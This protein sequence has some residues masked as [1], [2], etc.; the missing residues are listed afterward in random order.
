MNSITTKEAPMSPPSRQKRDVPSPEEAR[1]AQID[2]A[3][4]CAVVAALLVDPIG[5]NALLEQLSDEQLGRM[6]K[7]RL[8]KVIG[9][10]TILNLDLPSMRDEGEKLR[11]GVS[12]KTKLRTSENEDAIQSEST[13]SER[14][15]LVRQGKF[16]RTD[17]Y[18]GAADV[19]EKKLSKSLA[20]GKVFSVELEGEGYI[21]AFFLSPMIHHNDFANVLRNLGDTSG[22]N[23]WDF[24]TTPIEALRGSTPL[25][26]LALNK[27]KPVLRAAD[28]FAKSR[29]ADADDFMSIAE[30]AKLL[31]VSRAHVV[32]LLV[33]GKL[34][35]HHK[36]GNNQFVMKASV[37][38]YQ[39]EQRAAAKAY[40]ASTPEE[41]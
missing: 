16:L 28:E 22:W 41:E 10:S 32:K 31:F 29:H 35:L 23:R 8:W 27:V 1:L 36:T 2:H 39:A 38:N 30:V 20:S 34:K 26:F 12:R 25:Q 13:N 33:Q 18:L 3:I 9:V 40:Q 21:P 5:W 15:D 19:T 24:F 6:F 7:N 37:L 17:D 4:H 11:K 14:Y